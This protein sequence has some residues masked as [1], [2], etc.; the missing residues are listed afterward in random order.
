MAM[1]TTSNK[2]NATSPFLPPKEMLRPQPREP[3]ARL[4]QNDATATGATRS[5]RQR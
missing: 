2:P 3:Y 4:T 1:K 5:R